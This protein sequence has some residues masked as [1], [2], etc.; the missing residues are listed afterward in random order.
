MKISIVM[1]YYNRKEIFLNTLKSILR[2]EFKGEFEIIVVD[3]ASSEEHR[4]EDLIEV[5]KFLKIIRVEKEEK[6]WTNSC[7]PFNKAIN[8][9]TG[10]F[11]IIQNPECY[12]NGD[13]LSFVS[14]NLTNSNYLVFSCYSLDPT[15]TGRLFDNKEIIRNELS[16]WQNGQSAWYHHSSIRPVGY[17]FT[18][19][20]T[21]ENLSKLNGFDERFAKG[22]DWDDNE[23]LYRVKLF[24]SVKFVDSPFVYHQYHGDS[25]NR[26]NYLELH[27]RNKDLWQLVQIENKIRAN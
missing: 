26:P 8:S 5:Y 15:D 22:C 1:A 9:A 12:H 19:A 20:I 18:S 10:E 14:K 6:W 3:D 24:L 11:I 16:A 2:T 21:K 4:L 7:V 27:N 23:F 25:T 17:H 13:I